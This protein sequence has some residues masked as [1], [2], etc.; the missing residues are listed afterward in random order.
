MYASRAVHRCKEEDLELIQPYLGF[1]RLEVVRQTLLHTTQLAK[2]IIH[3]PLKK[4]FHARFW[5]LNHL[6]IHELISMD[7]L[8]A[9]CKG[10]TGKSCTQVFYGITS[11][12]MNIYGMKSKSEVLAIYKDFIREEIIPLILHQ[13]GAKEQASETMQ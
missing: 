8:F 10:V 11:H 2:P 12:V 5:Y 4:H 1:R 9:N 13:D 6:R 3:A 7:T